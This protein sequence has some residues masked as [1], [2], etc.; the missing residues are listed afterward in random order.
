[1][2]I[3]KELCIRQGIV[4]KELAS[5]VGVSQPTVSDWFNN[6]SDPSGKRLEKLSE[7]FGVS[8]AVI[9]GYDDQ[10]PKEPQKIDPHT[11]YAYKFGAETQEIVD[12]FLAMV[13]SIPD[14]KKQ[15]ETAEGAK[16]FA[17]GMLAKCEQEG[18]A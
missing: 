1:M 2:N 10:K 5:L 12:Q 7:I 15:L 17:Q 4:Q 14:Q 9:L 16:T 11:Y 6:K 8:R 3:V 18:K 13:A